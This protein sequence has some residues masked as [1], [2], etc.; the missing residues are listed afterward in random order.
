VRFF[1]DQDVYQITVDYLQSLGHDILRA[2]D[3]GLQRAPDEEILRYAHEHQRVLITRDKGFGALVFL[4]YQA[5]SGVILLRME[6]QT[7]DVVH[8]EL[9]RFLKEHTELDLHECFVVIEPGMHRIRK[10]NH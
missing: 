8:Q 5:H 7:I 9:A 6:P 3:V 4:S 1:I 2:S 10:R